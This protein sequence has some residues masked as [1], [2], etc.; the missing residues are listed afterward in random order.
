VGVKILIV[1]GPPASG[2][3]ITVG[4]A[5]VRARSFST[6]AL[7][8]PAALGPAS[9]AVAVTVSLKAPPATG[10][11]FNC[12]RVQVATFTLVEPVAQ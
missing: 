8:W 12:V 10:V 1:G 4:W 7:P 11:I 2:A 9:L 5:T 3:T 6:E